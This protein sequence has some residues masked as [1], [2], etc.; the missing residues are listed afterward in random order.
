MRTSPFSVPRV[1]KNRGALARKNLLQGLTPGEIEADA[2]PA[3]QPRQYSAGT[4]RESN[5]SCTCWMRPSMAVK[6][7]SGLAR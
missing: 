1:W 7:P 2:Q 6:K 3:G 5:S 4:V